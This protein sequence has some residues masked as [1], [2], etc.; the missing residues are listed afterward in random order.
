MENLSSVFLCA[1]CSR[2]VVP[3]SIHCVFA[4]ESRRTCLSTGNVHATE[5]RSA[6]FLSS[7]PPPHLLVRPFTAYMRTSI[8]ARSYADSSSNGALRP[9]ISRGGTVACAGSDGTHGSPQ[10]GGGCVRGQPGGACGATGEAHALR[11][12]VQVSR[13]SFF[14][15]CVFVL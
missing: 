6:R 4:G 14:F 15:F 7:S 12:V 3:F 13:G 2:L 1:S 11:G 5:L 8:H 10:R 9:G